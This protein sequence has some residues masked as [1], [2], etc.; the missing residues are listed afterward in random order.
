MGVI[1]Y[2][3]M[4]GKRPYHGK[5]RKEIRD[6]ILAKQV[7]IHSN[8]I[9]RDWSVQAADFINRLIMRKPGNRLGKEGPNQ[10][11]QH[12]WFKN[13]DWDSLY[14]KEMKAPFVPPKNEE[15]FDA[16][17]T[18]SDWKDANSEQMIAHAASLMNPSVQKQFEGYYHDETV[19]KVQKRE[20]PTSQALNEQKSH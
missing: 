6:H 2:E 5:D 18:N 1:A 15:N 19:A 3:C 4:F 17:Y 16:K 7:K 8:D 13:F 9:P 10:L 14:R 20:G 12:E 11:K